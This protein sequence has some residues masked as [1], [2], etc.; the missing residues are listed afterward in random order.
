MQVECGKEYVAGLIIG[1]ICVAYYFVK[2]TEISE[3]YI[4]G[5]YKTWRGSHTAKFSA[6]TGKEW[7]PKS[8][9]YHLQLT[10]QGVRRL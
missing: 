6:K 1:E 2:V 5:T 3:K 8:W 10:E 4:I 9:Y 7:R